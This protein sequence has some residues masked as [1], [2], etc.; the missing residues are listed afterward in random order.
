MVTV[1]SRTLD[2]IAVMVWVASVKGMLTTSVGRHAAGRGHF[3]KSR[4][5]TG[6]HGRHGAACGNAERGAWTIV[7]CRVGVRQVQD[8]QH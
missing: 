8:D 6:R 5:E 4:G 7:P 1:L 2:H 3:L